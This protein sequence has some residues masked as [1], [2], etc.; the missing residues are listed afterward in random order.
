MRRLALALGLGLALAAAHAQK[1]PATHVGVATRVFHPKEPVRNWRGEADRA[2]HVVIWYP[3]VSTAVETPQVV[4]P[5]GM[6]L[7]EAGSAAVDAP[8]EPA[9]KKG[10]PL[11]L[12][13]HGTGGSAIQMAWLGTALARAGFVAVAVDHPGNNSNAPMTPEGMAL[14]WERA[15]DLSQTLDMM[16]ADET[17]GKQIDPR[18]VGAA[19][20]SLGGYTVLELAGA[21]TDVSELLRACKQDTDLAV[22]HVPEARGM[23]S[24]EEILQ[25]VRQTSGESLARSGELYSDDR[26]S[27]VFAIAPALGFTLTQDSLNAIRMPVDMVVGDADTIAPAD[28]NAQLIRGDLRGSHVAVLPHVGHYTF[29]DTCTAAGKKAFDRYCTDEPGVNRDA[30]HE[31]VAAQVA[32]FFKRSLH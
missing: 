28:N 19:G 18:K 2:L 20:Y 9:K 14:W 29:L 23:G 24:P 13:S 26:I 21:Q 25:K 6:P 27:A 7:F 32:A 15:T 5:P 31:K 1:P 30:V 16:L 4:G 10:W 17:F 11:V 22:C 12:L 3:A 8:L